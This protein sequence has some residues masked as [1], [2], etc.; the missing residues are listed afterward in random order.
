[1]WPGAQTVKSRGIF[2]AIANN[3]L[4]VT[5]LNIFFY[6]KNYLYIKFMFHEDICKF[7]TVNISKRHFY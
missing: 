1:M 3:T 4:Y 5:K 2:V 6:A 7:P